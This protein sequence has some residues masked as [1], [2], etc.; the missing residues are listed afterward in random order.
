MKPNIFSY[1]IIL[2]ICLSLLLSACG[3]VK[4][5]TP[6]NGNATIDLSARLSQLQGTVQ[7]KN[8]DQADFS[9]AMEG[10]RLQVLGQVRSGAESGARLEFSTGTIV[11][12][13]PNTQFT[14]QSNAPKDN[15]L[16]T[17]LVVSAGQVWVILHGGLME[18][19]TPSGVATVHGS[20]MSVS[21]DPL[22][23]DVSVT[24]LEGW[25][26]AENP[27]AVMEMVA[28][29]GAS[30]YHWNSAG[31]TP[32]PPPKLHYL[33]QDEVDQFVKNNPEAEQIMNNIVATASALPTL[34]PTVTST[35]VAT[36]F[37]L[38]SP[39]NGDTLAPDGKLIFD[40][41]DQSEVYKYIITFTKPNGAEKSLIVWNSS[42]H[43]DS[44][45]LPLSGTYQWKVTAYDQNIQPICSAGPWT[46]V[47]PESSTPTPV[48][49]CFQLTGPDNEAQ[50][51]ATDPLTFTWDEQPGRYKYIIT[52]TK[53]DGSEDS[54]IDFANTYELPAGSLTQGGTYQWDVTAYDSNI[55]PICSAEPHTFVVPGESVPS[56]TPGGCV[57]LLTPP[58]G[59]NFPTPARVDFT[60]T[61]Y[62]GAYKY[63]ITFKP[64]SSPAFTFLAWKP[65]HTR[66][67]ESFTAGGTYKWWVTVKD[68]HVK[69][70]CTSQVFTFTKPET[71]LPTR[72]PSSGEGG[73]GTDLFWNRNVSLSGCTVSASADTSY[74]GGVKKLALSTNSSPSPEHYMVLSSL[75]GT[76]YGGST[77][78]TDVV[79]AFQSGKP[80][81]S[82]PFSPALISAPANPKACTGIPAGTTIYW[83][84]QV[85]DGEYILDNF[86]GSFVTTQDCP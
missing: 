70:I 2:I 17:R 54:Q 34:T 73:N 39:A 4:S 65:I 13:A 41:N 33:S 86:V 23:E 64:P 18:V 45:S 31:N 77:S 32:P 67:I 7:V 36:C 74:D 24:C 56:P 26:K 84:F 50:V 5:S 28:G 81:A 14:L 29:Q 20:Y 69:D 51:S 16:V 48:A 71:V 76:T 19:E 75:G 82:I 6:S 61:E 10:T 37:N 35:A 53:P 15:G 47:K 66:Y 83:R 30:L 12:V 72:S 40:W 57:T 79:T 58:D 49:D 68:Q 62:P 22:S 46:F 42:A 59:T 9:S 8:P 25:C 11:R 1:F 80:A 27:T 38:L 85:F 52:I 44:D 60:W 55:Q 63:I 21:V 3:A 78:L 43:I